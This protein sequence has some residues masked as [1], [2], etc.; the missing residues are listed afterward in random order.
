MFGRIGLA[1][2]LLVAV[3]Q[4][5]GCAGDL[6]K[7]D[8]AMQAWTDR[9]DHTAHFPQIRFGDQGLPYLDGAEAD[10]FVQTLKQL[11]AELETIRPP[12]E[13][14]AEHQRL[15][16]VYKRQFETMEQYIAAAL[17]HDLASME[18]LNQS[19]EDNRE[20]EE[21]MMQLRQAMEA[22]R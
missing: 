15:V 10:A 16:E 9:F 21:A 17:A 1:L 22:M 12:Q 5:L 4:A 14:A 20:F 6:D 2:V 13:I 3:F 7:Y 8:S 11:L 18:R 19:L